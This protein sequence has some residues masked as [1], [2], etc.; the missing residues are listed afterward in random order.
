MT[1]IDDE[2]RSVTVDAKQR[3]PL[4]G[5]FVCVSC[6]RV[7]EVVAAQKLPFC[8]CGAVRYELRRS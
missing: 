8:V 1:T 3:S 4:K 6:G 5:K 2:E 7:V